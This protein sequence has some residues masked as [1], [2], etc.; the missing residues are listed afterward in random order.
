MNLKSLL[1]GAAGGAALFYFLDPDSGKRRRSMATDRTA[2]TFR[3]AGRKG[4]QV[5]RATGA[6]AYGL[7]QK[8]THLQEEPK[9]YDD[10]TLARKVETE[11][12]RDADAPKGSVNVDAVDGV[13]TLRGEVDD[14]DL[15]KGLE[16]VAR[17]VQGVRD[18]ENLL[19][20]KG[21]PAPTRTAV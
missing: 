6:Q 18:V 20:M 1:F 21:T 15:I 16:K 19:H 9:D 11:I 2:A 13:V 10:T 12:F 3:R 4:E 8:A 5:V 14:P 17:K 7:Q